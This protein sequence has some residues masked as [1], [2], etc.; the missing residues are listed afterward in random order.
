M[1]M[2]LIGLFILSVALG[3]QYGVAVGF[4]TLGGGLIV[5]NVLHTFFKI[6][7]GIL[8]RK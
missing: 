4:I 8:R 5:L 2:S 3:T 7:I 6:A 1:E